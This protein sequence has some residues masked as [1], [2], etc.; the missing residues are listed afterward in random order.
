MKPPRLE[1]PDAE[2]EQFLVHRLKEHGLLE[3]A[4]LEV[5]VRQGVAYIEGAVPNLKQKRLAGEIARQIAGIR[6]IVNRLRILPLPVVDDESLKKHLSQTLAQN[7][8][9]RRC[10]LSIEVINGVVY[11][12]GSVATATEKRLAEHEAWA[13][14]GVRDIKNKIEVVSAAPRSEM[15]IASEIRESFSHCL[16]IDLNQIVVEVKEG[17]VYL[18]GTVPTDYLKEAAEE[19]ATWTP[20]VTGVVNELTVLELP[21]SRR[22]SPPR[23][24]RSAKENPVGLSSPT[25]ELGQTREPRS[26][27]NA[28]KAIE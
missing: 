11:L 12:A 8:R 26:S 16:G 17:R 4:E 3:I 7:P 18:R 23:L 2:A 25:L 13:T 5:R 14:P 21:G 27:T 22:Y 15:E 20:S 19:L 10:R 28:K 6:D 9:T 24:I 1:T